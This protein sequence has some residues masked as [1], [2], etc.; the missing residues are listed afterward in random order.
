MKI[1]RI[2]MHGRHPRFNLETLS[3]GTEPLT[4]QTYDVHDDTTETAHC[5]GLMIG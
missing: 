2:I 4:L 1:V 5:H 3:Q